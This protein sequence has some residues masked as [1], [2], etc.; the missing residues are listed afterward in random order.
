MQYRD[1]KSRT[2]FPTEAGWQAFINFVRYIHYAEPFATRS[3]S[4]DTYQAVLRAYANMLSDRLLPQTIEDLVAYLPA[5]FK[6]TLSNRAERCF[7]NVH[8]IKNQE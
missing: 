3:T 2:Y 8:G 5:S 6:A 4:N 1:D 7:S